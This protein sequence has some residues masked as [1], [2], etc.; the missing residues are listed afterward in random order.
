MA[1]RASAGKLVLG[2]GAEA[3]VDLLSGDVPD[4]DF[5][6][7]E[8]AEDGE[9]D[10]LAGDVTGEALGG[11]AELFD[12]R[13]GKWL[14]PGHWTYLAVSRRAAWG[15]PGR[16]TRAGVGRLAEGDDE[17]NAPAMNRK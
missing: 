15:W 11:G 3:E 9:G 7:V 17:R 4:G 1:V 14:T 8:V 12:E 2:G 5:L 10:A 13:F 6:V 16:P